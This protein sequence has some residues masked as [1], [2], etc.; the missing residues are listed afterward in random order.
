MRRYTYKRNQKSRK[1]KIGFFTAFSICIVAIGLALWSTFA[2]IGGFE[3]RNVTEATYVATFPQFTEAVNKTVTGLT[4]TEEAEVTETEPAETE[5]SSESTDPEEYTGENSNLQTM[6]QV[7]ASLDYPVRSQKVNKEYSENAV[8]NE[9]M[10]DYRAHTGVDFEAGLGE[11]VV[12]MSDG[13]VESIYTD[14]MYGN[15]IKITNGNFS[16]YY[17]GMSETV[18]CVEGGA[19]TKGDIIGKVGEVPCEVADGEHLHVEVRVGD[20]CIDPLTVISSD[21]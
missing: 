14:G 12:A 7:S 1:E 9:T 21:Q 20:K 3:K 16:V 17:C 4:V 13:T 8:Y 19:V 18:Y 6:L 2:S 11:N 15:I 5:P 10:N